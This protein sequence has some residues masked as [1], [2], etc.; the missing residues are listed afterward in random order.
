[1]ILSC[2]SDK[3]EIVNTTAPTKF[4]GFY[5]ITALNDSLIGPYGPTFNIDNQKKRVYG[6]AG[7]NSYNAEF[8]LTN[9]KLNIAPPLHTKKACENTMKLERMILR[10]IPKANRYTI[11]KRILTLYNNDQVIIV[12][13][14]TDY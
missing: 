12:A 8:R 14:S 2:G 10:A 9:G 1:M 7:C 4:K 3:K 5:S 13:K 6:F 11:E